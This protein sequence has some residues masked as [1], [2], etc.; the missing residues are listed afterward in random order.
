MAWILA[1]GKVRRFLLGT[2]RPGTVRARLAERG[3]DCRGCAACCKL[4]YRCPFLDESTSPARCSVYP[5]RP[6]NCRLFPIDPRDL[7]ERD[8]VSPEEACGFTFPVAESASPGGV[9]PARG[10]GRAA[11]V[12][13]P[14][15]RRRRYGEAGGGEDPPGA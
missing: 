2:F 5:H 6:K 9:A 10:N 1:S 14:A 4:L 7:M 13:V 12:V 3:G 15:R 11:R 8:L